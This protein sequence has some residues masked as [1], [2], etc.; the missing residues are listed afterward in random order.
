MNI[1][2]EVHLQHWP[3]KLHPTFQCLLL[4]WKHCFRL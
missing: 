3:W 2:V 1:L 4:F